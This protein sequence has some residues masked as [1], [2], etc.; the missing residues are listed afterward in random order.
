MTE[1]ESLMASFSRTEVE[2]DNAEVGGSTLAI[3]VTYPLASVAL[4]VFD[5]P[6]G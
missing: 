5:S 2:V 3:A 6:T 1:Q 4:L